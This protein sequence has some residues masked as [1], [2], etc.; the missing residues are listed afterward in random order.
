MPYEQLLLV[1][2]ELKVR[3]K[4]GREQDATSCRGV[5]FIRATC[6]SVLWQSQLWMLHVSWSTQHRALYLGARWAG[7]DFPAF[8]QGQHGACGPSKARALPS[9]G[10]LRPPCPETDVVYLRPG[11]L[12]CCAQLAASWGQMS[13]SC[14]LV[15]TI[16]LT[17]EP[18]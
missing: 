7:E 15:P 5:E 2:A 8:Q 4:R 13:H 6:G 1:A 18:P 14:L 11:H 16:C 12:V 9:A 17:L 3:G 10:L